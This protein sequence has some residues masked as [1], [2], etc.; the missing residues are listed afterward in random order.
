MTKEQEEALREGV[1]RQLPVTAKGFM[2]EPPTPSMVGTPDGLRSRA[3]VDS[4][5][6]L[7]WVVSKMDGYDPQFLDGGYHLTK[8][9]FFNDNRAAQQGRAITPL[10][11]KK[12]GAAYRLTAIGKTR[13]NDGSG[14]QTSPFEAVEG[15]DVV[16]EGY[17]FGWH[18]G[19]SGT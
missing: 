2:P 1:S 10:I 12:E 4:A 3:T 8:W 15:S 7:I 16:G 11:F 13:T 5:G 6:G 9:S 17:Y 19:G 18:T 14:L